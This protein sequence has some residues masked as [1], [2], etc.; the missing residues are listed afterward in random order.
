MAI[1]AAIMP[2]IIPAVTENNAP[3]EIKRNNDQQIL[4]IIK[5]SLGKG[6]ISE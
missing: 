2:M 1:T 3:N 5:F 6:I 4:D